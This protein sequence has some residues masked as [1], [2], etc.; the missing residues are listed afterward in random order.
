MTDLL[1]II[2]KWADKLAI[3]VTA[4]AII[5]VLLFTYVTGGDVASDIIT[6]NDALAA[7]RDYD[8]NAEI[9]DPNY[10]LRLA[11]PDVEG[12]TRLITDYLAILKSA[13]RNPES[14]PL[15]STDDMARQKQKS[16]AF[17]Y[18]PAVVLKAVTD[19]EPVNGGDEE[20]ESKLTKP[21]LSLTALSGKVEVVIAKGIGTTP[22]EAISEF[23]LY[24]TSKKDEWDLK[25]IVI[26]P[27]F[28][29][30]SVETTYIDDVEPDAKYY[31]RVK[32]V[33][34]REII[35]DEVET[36]YSDVKEVFVEAN[37]KFL[38]LMSIQKDSAQFEIEKLFGANDWKKYKKG[39]IFKVG[40]KIGKVVLGPW[41]PIKRKTPELDFTTPFTFSLMIPVR[42]YIW[43]KYV[44]DIYGPDGRKIDE[45][46][47]WREDKILPYI[48]VYF[49]KNNE[50]FYFLNT[51]KAEDYNTWASK[52]V[53]E[54]SRKAFNRFKRDC[55]EKMEE[56]PSWALEIH[57]PK[58][59]ED[60]GK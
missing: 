29:N 56:D 34:N 45:E 8:V 20:P 23:K 6:G 17:K 38:P 55:E 41:D 2:V 53:F 5:F 51:G 39:M 32:A 27:D 48:R 44:K 11:P 58:P 22:D 43:V 15:F 9:D 50:V 25:P 42:E 49:S 52:G 35:P 19:G 30:D 33:A 37:V 1:Q 60:K 26:E 13:K 46:I 16:T 59:D 12:D 24:R 40:E 28:G 18:P 4:L 47:T 14:D 3:G 54:G 7:H 21:R 57:H 36:E 31:Y 10:P